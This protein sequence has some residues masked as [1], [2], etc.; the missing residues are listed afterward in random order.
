MLMPAALKIIRQITALLL[1]PLL[2]A[3]ATG[4]WH[5]KRPNWNAEELKEGEVRLETVLSWDAE[6]YIWIDARPRK[7]YEAE[8][9]PGAFLL[10]EDEW[11]DLLF[12]VLEPLAMG[13]RVVVYCSSQECQ[14][15]AQVARRL[16]EEGFAQEVHVLKDGWTAWRNR[17]K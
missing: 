15:S 2:P 7:D 4:L 5:P 14:A 6:E 13:K 16:K 8:H 17:P 3:I 11:S 10:N 12:D 9:I 1:L